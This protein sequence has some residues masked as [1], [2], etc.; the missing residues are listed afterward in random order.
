MKIKSLLRWYLSDLIVLSLVAGLAVIVEMARE[1]RWAKSIP[2][3]FYYLHTTVIALVIHLAV[4]FLCFF[5]SL[6]ALNLWQMSWRLRSI[7]LVLFMGVLL[8]IATYIFSPRLYVSLCSCDSFAAGKCKAFSEAQEI[9]RR[10]HRE[11]A[12]TLEKLVK[13]NLL[14]EAFA[15]AVFPNGRPQGGTLYKILFA[16]GPHAIGGRKSYLD[17]DGKMTLGYALIASPA[18]YGEYGKSSFIISSSGYIYWCDLGPNTVEIVNKMSVFDPTSE[19]E[20]I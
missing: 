5:L 11:Y 10:T 4:V 14:E 16:Q 12:D 17:G 15:T 8:I 6:A 3:V 1:G 9:Y 13:E 20:E 2:F 7:M 18:K 19:W